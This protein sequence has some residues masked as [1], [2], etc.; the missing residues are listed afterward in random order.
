MGADRSQTVLATDHLIS[1]Y[2]AE[3]YEFVTVP[4]MMEKASAG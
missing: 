1:R 2:K 4:K 3:G